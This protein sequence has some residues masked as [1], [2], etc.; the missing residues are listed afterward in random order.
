[1]RAPVALL[2]IASAAHADPTTEV[3]ALAGSAELPDG[4]TA[5]TFLHLDAHL[6]V[7]VDR[8]EMRVHRL[9]RRLQLGPNARVVL[10]TQW[11][12]VDHEIAARGWHTALSGSYDVGGV[13]IATTAGVEHV[14]TDLGRDSLM[15]TAIG[16]GKGFRISRSVRAWVGLSLSHRRWLGKPPAGESDATQLMLTGKL[17]Y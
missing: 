12:D 1:M 10:Q 7:T 3:R 13:R 4:D 5:D 17:T 9:E 2:M 8:L 16:I 6:Q 11:R 15:T 14:D